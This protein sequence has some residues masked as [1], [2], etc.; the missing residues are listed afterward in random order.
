M[1]MDWF[2]M[3]KGQDLVQQVPI[4]A[5]QWLTHAESNNYLFSHHQ[6]KKVELNQSD[7]VANKVSTLLIQIHKMVNTNS[8]ECETLVTSS[9]K[10]SLIQLMLSSLAKK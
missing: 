6:F 5:E 10:N 8:K 7:Q 3:I 9:M 4:L 1:M 2:Q